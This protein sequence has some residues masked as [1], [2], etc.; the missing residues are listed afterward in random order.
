M[1]VYHGGGVNNYSKRQDL[2]ISWVFSVLVWVNIR[3]VLF[4]WIA[5]SCCLF[6]GCG[7]VQT[8]AA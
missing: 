2:F 3:S 5:E 1:I 7:G 6:N 4:R 8:V